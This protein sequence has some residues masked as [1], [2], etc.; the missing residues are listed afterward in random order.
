MDREGLRWLDPFRREAWEYALGAAEE[1]A[2]LGFDEIQFDYLRFPDQTG[3]V[4]AEENTAQ[5]RMRAI[6]DFLDEARRRL[7]PYN[8]TVSADIFG[9]VCWNEGEMGIGQGI[10][11]LARG[12]EMLSPML[13]PSGYQYGIPGFRN[14]V[15]HP[16]EIVRLSLEKA[17]R[18]T[19]WAAVRFRP[20]LQ[21]FRDYGFDRRKFGAVEIGLQIRAAE[22]FGSGGWMLWNSRNQYSEEGLRAR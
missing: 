11:D 13:Y 14:P 18:R 9:Y 6:G 12:V 17:R 4:F 7:A 16:Y 3:L 2:G 8:V 10:E 21:A 5:N 20:W 22:E 1:A 19:G 15:A